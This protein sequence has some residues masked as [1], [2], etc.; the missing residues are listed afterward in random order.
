MA[1]NLEGIFDWVLMLLSIVEVIGITA[2]SVVGNNNEVYVYIQFC[3]MGTAF[4]KSPY[5][6]LIYL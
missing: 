5:I 1:T 3:V 6:S 2:L 4:T